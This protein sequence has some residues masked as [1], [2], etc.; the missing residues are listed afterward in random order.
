[1]F[2]Y[3]FEGWTDHEHLDLDMTSNVIVEHGE[4]NHIN[5]KTMVYKVLS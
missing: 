1:M 5:C 2:K 3:P 4:K